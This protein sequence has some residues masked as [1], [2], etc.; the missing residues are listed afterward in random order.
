[1]AGEPNACLFLGRLA[2][3]AERSDVVEDAL[4]HVDIA[5]LGQLEAQLLLKAH[6]EQGNMTDAVK[7][8][9][10]ANIPT[11]TMVE[12]AL[13]ADQNRDIE[14]ARLWL[15]AAELHKDEN[16]AWGTRRWL[17]WL[18]WSVEKN[19]DKALFYLEPV[20]A[21]APGAMHPKLLLASVYQDNSID[22]AI[23][24][25]ESAYQ[26]DPTNLEA[27]YRLWHAYD[28]RGYDGDLAKRDLLGHHASSLILKH[29]RIEPDDAR[30]QAWLEKIRSSS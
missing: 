8:I 29:L 19:D 17:G 18:W 3:Y 28:E 7:L 1:M 4:E 21:Q 10:F 12:W 25:L 6:Y 26:L 11:E 14:T 2:S 16:L 27:L 15:H 23:A 30:F 24:V 13:Q 22:K 9:E 20:A 5:Q